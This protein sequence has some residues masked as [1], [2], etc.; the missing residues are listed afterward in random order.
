[1]ER[2][3]RGP[4]PTPAA[5]SS[6]GAPRAAMRGPIRRARRAGGLALLRAAAAKVFQLVGQAGGEGP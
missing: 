4:R 2:R 6:T 5:R 3:P 1:V